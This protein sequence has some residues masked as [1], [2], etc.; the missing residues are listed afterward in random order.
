MGSELVPLRV[1]MRK[2]KACATSYQGLGFR[3]ADPCTRSVL[4]ND[5]WSLSLPWLLSMSRSWSLMLQSYFNSSPLPERNRREFGD[6]PHAC[7]KLNM[8][9]SGRQRLNRTTV[10]VCYSNLWTNTSSI[11]SDFISETQGTETLN[12]ENTLTVQAALRP[13]NTP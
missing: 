13:L 1:H 11:A 8:A 12:F 10:T 9:E 2:R 4:L 3:V 6:L 5:R 7:L